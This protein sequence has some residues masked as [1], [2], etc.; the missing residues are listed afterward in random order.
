M[1]EKAVHF[2][3]RSSTIEPWRWRGSREGAVKTILPLLLLALTGCD[4]RPGGWA[5][6]VYPDRTDR[7]RFIV[8]P[9]FSMSSYC[10]EAAKETMNRIQVG[11][12]GAYECGYNCQLDGDPHKMNVCE[13]IRK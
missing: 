7:T 6:I 2:L 12:G 5:A 4:G 10:L 11:A 1:V 9:H 13:K 8:T 3:A